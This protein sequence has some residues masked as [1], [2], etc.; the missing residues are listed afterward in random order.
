MAEQK[1]IDVNS[2]MNNIYGD[3][4]NKTEWTVGWC[5]ELEHQIVDDTFVEFRCKNSTKPTRTNRR[6]TGFRQG[7]IVRLRNKCISKENQEIFDFIV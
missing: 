7:M 2:L 3:F 6:D 5:K 1:I 4:Y